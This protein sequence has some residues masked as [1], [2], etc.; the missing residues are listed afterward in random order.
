VI[1][2]ANAKKTF[3]HVT[4]DYAHAWIKK[5]SWSTILTDGIEVREYMTYGHIRP[6]LIGEW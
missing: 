6:I 2:L 5:C 4:A 3:R 1:D